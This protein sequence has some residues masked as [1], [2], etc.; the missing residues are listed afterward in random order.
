MSIFIGVICS[1]ILNVLHLFFSLYLQARYLKC[2]LFKNAYIIT[3][4]FCNKLKKYHSDSEFI[5]KTVKNFSKIPKHLTFALGEEHVSYEDLVQI[6]LWSLPAGVPV[7]SF[8]DHKDELDADKLY[9]TFHKTYAEL[10]LC[11]KWGVSFS[12]KHSYEE[13]RIDG[14]SSYLHVNV[15]SSKHGPQLLID[16]L[17]ELC[18]RSDLILTD[19]AATESALDD[20]MLSKLSYCG[21][22]DLLVIN[23]NVYT[24]YGLS[25]WHVGFT[26]FL[27]TPCYRF[28]TLSEFLRMLKSYAD[29]E[30]KFGR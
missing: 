19:R 16:S 15:L 21:N 8:Y 14:I 12:R 6:I 11:I 20:V 5:E 28:L 13:I 29:C 2:L 4:L 25:P 26:E 10:A 3:N 27:T 17:K 18:S 9:E 1:F 24:T 23:G 22:P 30:Q 7:L